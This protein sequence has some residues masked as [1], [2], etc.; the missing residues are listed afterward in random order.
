ARRGRARRRRREQRGEV[1]A[2]DLTADQRGRVL[3][4]PVRHGSD[5]ERRQDVPHDQPE[6]DDAEEA[7]QG[8]PVREEPPGTLQRP[9]EGRERHRETSW[10]AAWGAARA[11]PVTPSWPSGD[12]G[13]RLRGLPTAPLSDTRGDTRGPSAC[14]SQASKGSTTGEA[15]VAQALSRSR[16][17]PV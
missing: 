8:E 9:H 13:G 17:R 7:Q 15:A 16:G 3:P 14:E 11:G 10:G 6:G 12:A 5:Q 2:L 1:G 4:L